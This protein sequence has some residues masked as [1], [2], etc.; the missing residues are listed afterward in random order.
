[1]HKLIKN[2]TF[3]NLVLGPKCIGPKFF[4]AK[5][6]RV[7]VLMEPKYSLGQNEPWAE[8]CLGPKWSWCQTVYEPDLGY[9]YLSFGTFDSFPAGLGKN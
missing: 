2:Y 8:V 6:F 7:E 9:S 5:Y 1:M 4:W 3:E